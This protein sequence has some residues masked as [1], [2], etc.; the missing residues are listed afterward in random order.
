MS[1]VYGRIPGYNYFMIETSNVVDPGI[2]DE[3]FPE[4]ILEQT[5]RPAT[6]AEYIGQ[7][8][9]KNTLDVI[10]QA[11]KKRNEQIEH[12]LFYGPPGLGKTTLAFII[13]AEFG[14]TPKVT[15]GVAIERA[16]DLASI[17]TSLEDGDILFIDEIHRLNK[18]I[19]EILYPAME[20]RVLDIMLGKGQ[21]ARSI[22][23]ELPRF[24]LIGA[25]TQIG[26]IASPLRDR[27]GAS[28]RLEYYNSSELQ[29]IIERSGRILG[30][31]IE[32]DGSMELAQ[33]SRLTPRIANRL[34][35]RVRDYALVKTHDT[36]TANVVKDALELM[37]IDEM[38][39]D[40]NDR[41]ILLTI[42]EKFSGG[43]IGLSTL[44]HATSEEES[45][46]ASVIEPFLIRA[47]LLART[48][49]GRVVTESAYTH[50]G[51][52]IPLRLKNL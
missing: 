44:A 38:G 12:L 6:L 35:K 10:M 34:L 28:F 36:I 8:S 14:K 37:E 43:P 13:A 29:K 46:I 19:E 45:T 42:V 32:S 23:M 40:R 3:V 4:K 39:L 1:L 48:P 30:A 52:E 17:L 51:K 21:G 24:T 2:P 26:S 31:S 20:D 25:T 33:R 18:S 49:K 9:V 7:E 16:G 15:T 50:L 27:F 41:R 22:R 47:G 5:L 11:A